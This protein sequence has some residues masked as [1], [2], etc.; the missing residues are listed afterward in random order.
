M[1][2]SADTDFGTLLALRAVRRPSVLLWRRNTPRRP[3][4]QAPV[5]LDALARAERDLASG[6]I[7]VIEATRL[8][9]RQLPI[10]DAAP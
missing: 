4:A 6:A 1:V 10:G 9:V 3:A 7:V 5:I 2:V 8:R